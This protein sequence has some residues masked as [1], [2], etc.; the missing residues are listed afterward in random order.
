MLRFV[1]ALAIVASAVCLLES[2]PQ[3]ARFTSRATGVRVDALVLQGNKPVGGLAASDFEVRDNGVLQTI[4][5]V[6]S[7]DVPINVLLALDTS[8]SVEGR[9]LT[10]L[11]DAGRTLFDGLTPRDRGALATFNHAV[12]PRVSLTS[13]VASLKGALDRI[14]PSGATAIMDGVYVALVATLA[15]PGR[16][17][18]VVCTDGRDTASWLQADEVIETAKRSNA[19]IYAVAAGAAGRESDLKALAEL[20]GGQLIEVEKSSGYT[21]Q[22]RRILTE[23]R[24]RYVLSFTP[25]GVASGGFHRLDVKVRR[26]GTT[27]KARQGYISGG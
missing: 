4:D 1:A 26:S 17:L 8:G 3:Q 18:V 5:A 2:A 16:S 10:D 27:V 25:T 14:V 24:S 22:L 21:A 7:N 9:R 23:F 20:T 6:E 19:V 11:V 15:E 12:T 13:D